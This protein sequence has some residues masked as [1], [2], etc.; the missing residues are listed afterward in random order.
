MTTTT[1]TIT[2]DDLAWIA[3]CL[4]YQARDLADHAELLADEARAARDRMADD[5]DDYEQRAE[6][7]REEHARTVALHAILAAGTSI[8][9]N[10]GQA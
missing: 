8:T 10:G 2:G 1:T 9:I 7:K 4:E 6:W 3:E 5:A